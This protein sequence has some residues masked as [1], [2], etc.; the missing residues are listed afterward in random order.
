M[1]DSD[2]IEEIHKYFSDGNQWNSA[3][4]CA[5]LRTRLKLAIKQQKELKKYVRHLDGFRC[6][7][8]L[9]S[10]GEGYFYETDDPNVQ[11]TCGV[12]NL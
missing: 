11:C 7:R 2:N 4:E 5:Y 1:L 3:G 8:V 9:W 10:N 6:D 12:S